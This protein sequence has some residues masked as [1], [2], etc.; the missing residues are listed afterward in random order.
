MTRR[1]SGALFEL[2]SCTQEDLP[3]LFHTLEMYPKQCELLQVLFDLCGEGDGT[4]DMPSLCER[5]NIARPTVLQRLARL[6]ELGIVSSEMKQVY[7]GAR[8]VNV[9]RI[10]RPPAAPS[11]QPPSPA[12]GHEL[13]A[14]VAPNSESEFGQ[15]GELE[16]I[17]RDLVGHRELHYHPD[18]HRRMTWKADRLIVLSFLAGLRVGKTGVEVSQ[19]QTRI[20]MGDRYFTLQVRAPTGAFIPSVVDLRV[21]IVVFSLIRDSLFH[22]KPVSDDGGYLIKMEEICAAMSLD[23]L[24]GNKRHLYDQLYRWRYSEF[25]ITGDHGALSFA[26]GVF[27]KDSSFNVISELHVLKHVT[28]EGKTPELVYLALAPGIQR[29]LRDLKSTLSIHQQILRERKPKPQYHLVY[30]WCRRVVQHA[31]QPKTFSLVHMHREIRPQLSLKRFR[32]EFLEVLRDHYVPGEQAT[33]IPGYL[34]RYHRER[35]E[36]SIMADPLDP[37]VGDNS[38]YRLAEEK[39]TA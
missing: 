21:L 3:V 27:E 22:N 16:F 2:G 12:V 7:E 33:K 11:L 8:S 30:Y 20:Y 9:Y 4:T 14:T 37:I 19:K 29:E 28:K 10:R 35:D 25:V 23:P 31:E 38:P 13:P 34:L 36:V 18:V 24:P 32:A 17:G 6:I 5:L 39:R 15:Q 1:G 26:S